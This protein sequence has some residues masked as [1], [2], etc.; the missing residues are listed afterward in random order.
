M[1]MRIF[2]AKLQNIYDCVCRKSDLMSY[3][4]TTKGNMHLLIL[5]TMQ[6]TTLTADAGSTKTTWC[7]SRPGAP[8]VFA[9][10]L[11]INPFMMSEED[12]IKSVREEL[13]VKQGFDKADEIRFFGAGCRGEGTVR[14]K[15]A[16]REL[17]PMAQQVTVGSDIVGAANALFGAEGS[18]IACIMGTGSNSCL[19]LEGEM[20]ENISP[21]GYI[22]G[23]EGSGAVLG[24]RLVGDVLK[25][26]LPPEVCNDFL[27]E[28]GLSTDGIIERVYRQPLPNRFLAS[29]APFIVAHR[30]EC[31][32]LRQLVMDE[33]VR[34][35]ERNVSLY[36]RKDLAV[37]FVGGIAWSLQD[38][39]REV[40]KA[41]GYKTGRIL[42]EPLGAE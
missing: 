20:V 22:L 28:Y 26:Q 36:G 23:D 17:W 6:K 40:A 16:L 9:T 4:R 10:T 24:R 32:A 31:G 34:F 25:R 37:G 33:F 18:G 5:Q 21:L 19:Y 8:D 35:F 15:K 42:R 29:F 39:I 14:I 1:G 38:E 27:S 7:S 12:I 3:F 2:A 13:L 11:G 30:R 41:L